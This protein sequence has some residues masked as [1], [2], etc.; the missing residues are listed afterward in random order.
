MLQVGKMTVNL[1]VYIFFRLANFALIRC[2]AVSSPEWSKCDPAVS[3]SSLNQSRPC[4]LTTSSI[5]IHV[6]ARGWYD[7]CFALM[8]LADSSFF[9]GR[10]LFC[11]LF[12]SPCFTENLLFTWVGKLYFIGEPLAGL[13][14]L[15]STH[16]CDSPLQLVSGRW[17][18]L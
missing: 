10:F 4:V 12:L 8:D 11:G 15:S 5:M 16:C 14:Q 13:L 17:R 9:G 1:N 6:F 2:D 18:S 3:F 7:S